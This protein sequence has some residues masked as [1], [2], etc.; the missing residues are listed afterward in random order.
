MTFSQLVIRISKIRVIKWLKILIFLKILMNAWREQLTV[1]IR[2]GIVTILSD[3]TT[4]VVTR[5]TMAMDST[6]RV[7]FLCKSNLC[8]RFFL[9]RFHQIRVRQLGLFFLIWVCFYSLKISTNVT[10]GHVTA[11]VIA[12]TR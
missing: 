10:Y 8:S 11:M 5:D 9:V 6:A 1:A 12:I 3:R 7:I 4:V 2:M